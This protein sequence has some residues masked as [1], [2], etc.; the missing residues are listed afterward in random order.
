MRLSDFLEETLIGISSNKARSGL[1]I[2]GIVIGIAAVIAMLSIGTGVQT[3]ITSQ[4]ASNGSNLLTVIPGSQQT[5]GSAVR[6][7][8]GSA[9]TVTVQDYENIVSGISGIEAIAPE[10]DKSEQVVASGNNTNSQIIGTTTDYQTIKNIT[11]QSGTFITSQS[12]SNYLRVAILGATIS[13]DLFGTSNPVGKTVLINDIAFTVIGVD[14]SQGG[15]SFMSPDNDVF[16][17]ITTM[18]QFISGRGL[19]NYVS[20]INVE[21]QSQD[22]MTAVQNSITS[23]LLKDH[24]ISNPSN[25]DFTVENQASLMQLASTVT[26]TLTIFLAAIAGISLLVGGIGIM[27]MM[28]TTVTERTREIGIRKAIGAK[29]RDIS[30]Q[31]LFESIELSLLGSAIGIALGWAIAMLIKHYVPSIPAQVSLNSVLLSVG[32]CG[33]IGIVF[34]YYPARRASGLNPIEALRY[35]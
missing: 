3:S 28:L 1:T 10:I 18:Q 12:I 20:Q 32:V 6:G 14:A 35:E 27:N 13:S 22:Q 4:V 25:A 23:L 17:P 31:F 21:A 34:G 7:A 8:R 15:S 24:N 2:L 11:A 30:L 16:I 33:F 19:N 29:D 5:V 9:T 26:N